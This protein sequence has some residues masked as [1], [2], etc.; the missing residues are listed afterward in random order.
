[1]RIENLLKYSI[2]MFAFA[3]LGANAR[4]VCEIKESTATSGGYRELQ[5]GGHKLV[6][7]DSFKEV[8]E[9]VFYAT[10]PVYGKPEIGMIDC[11]SYKYTQL[12][13]PKNIDKSY[14]DGTDFFRLKDIIKDK[15]TGIY[16]LRYFYA[17]NVDSENFKNF[18]IERNLRSVKVPRPK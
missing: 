7:V 5:V 14:P 6:D 1:M 12:V 3:L 15:K 13:A 9:K 11:G 4:A 16:T 10:S 2:A 18:E 8:D 17:P